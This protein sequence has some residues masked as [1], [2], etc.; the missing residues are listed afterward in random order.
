[1]ACD[2]LPCQNGAACYQQETNESG[3]YCLCADG[4]QGDN[5]EVAL[6]P[7]NPDP[8]RNGAACVEDGTQFMCLCR[9]GFSGD[10]CENG[11][12]TFMYNN[13]LFE[14]YMCKSKLFR[15]EPYQPRVRLCLIIVLR[16]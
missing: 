7:C 8:C 13:A 16:L 11:N 4:Y 1:M 9:L 15:L 6:T 5:C 3:Y 12:N 2:L 14:I 10:L